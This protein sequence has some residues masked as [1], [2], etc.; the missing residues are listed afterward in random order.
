MY[1]KHYN[2]IAA[3]LRSGK[4][5]ET[6]V[7]DIARTLSEQ[8]SN[9]DQDRFIDKALYGDTQEKRSKRFVVHL[10]LLTK[11]GAKL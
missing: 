3:A 9:C 4:A 2:A 1:R 7:R 5:N 11:R 10:A 8:F 6:T